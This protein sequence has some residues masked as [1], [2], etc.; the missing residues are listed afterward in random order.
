MI[1]VLSVECI[2]YYFTLTHKKK[3]GW[4]QNKVGGTTD[5]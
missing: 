3:T 4:H 1:N 2:I 5:F